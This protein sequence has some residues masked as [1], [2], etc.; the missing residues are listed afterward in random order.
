MWGLHQINAAAAWNLTTGSPL[1]II[2]DIDTG[3]DRTHPDLA[4]LS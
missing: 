2:A 4:G 3:V 1:M